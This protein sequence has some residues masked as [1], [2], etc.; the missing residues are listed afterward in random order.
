M[1]SFIPVDTK[2]LVFLISLAKPKPTLIQH[3]GHHLTQPVKIMPCLFYRSA[4]S[5]PN[6]GLTF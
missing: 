1:L 5:G 6:F 4:N 2:R 3:I